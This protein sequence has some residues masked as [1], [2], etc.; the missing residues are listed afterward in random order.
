MGTYLT[1]LEIEELDR[2]EATERCF[3]SVPFL[4][5]IVFTVNIFGIV[6]FVKDTQRAARNFRPVSS[7]YSI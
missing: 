3:S 7:P 5:K 6:F 2:E 1:L 4:T